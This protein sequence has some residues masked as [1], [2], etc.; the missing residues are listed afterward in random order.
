MALLAENHPNFNW[1]KQTNS[2]N[3]G[4]GNG[5]GQRYPVIKDEQVSQYNSS[6]VVTYPFWAGLKT[7]VKVRL[8]CAALP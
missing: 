7:N 8:R 6:G 1:S 5:G 3:G 4:G 2:S